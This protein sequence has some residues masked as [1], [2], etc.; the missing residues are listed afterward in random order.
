[1]KCYSYNL[2]FEVFSNKTRLKII[3]ALASGKKSVSEICEL[4]NEEQSKVSHNLKKL[5]E[6][7]FVDCKS[8]GKKR[9]YFLNKGTIEPILKLVEKHVQKYCKGECNRK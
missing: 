6:C 1:M 3:E 2:F 7:H 5:A 4:I 9:I 8:K